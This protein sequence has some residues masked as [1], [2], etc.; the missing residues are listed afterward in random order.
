MVDTKYLEAIE[1]SFLLQRLIEQYQTQDQLVIAYDFDDTV[2]PF[3]S[4]NCIEVQS[5]LRMSKENLNA[6]FI[7]YTCNTNREKIVKFLDYYNLPYDVINAP[8]P[9]LPIQ[10]TELGEKLYFNILLDDKAG[11]GEATAALKTL[12]RLVS[13]GVIKKNV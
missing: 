3:R 8:A 11:L 1:P 9:F 2:S 6:F 7:V 12:N 5:V 10:P 13:Q 4:S